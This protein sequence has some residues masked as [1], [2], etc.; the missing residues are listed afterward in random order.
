[1]EN[2]IPMNERRVV[3]GNYPYKEMNEQLSGLK[4]VITCFGFMNG[5]LLLVFCMFFYDF[6]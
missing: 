3:N 1:M 6:R 2:V 4:Y 5:N